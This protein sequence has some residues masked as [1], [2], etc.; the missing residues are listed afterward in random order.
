MRP[1]APLVRSCRLSGQPFLPIDAVG[2]G[3]IGFSGLGLRGLTARS[4]EYPFLF[5]QRMSPSAPDL[6]IFGM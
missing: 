6:A 2:L 5:V 3:L 4:V 1:H